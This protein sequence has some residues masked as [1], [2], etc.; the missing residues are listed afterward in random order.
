MHVSAG[1]LLV[2]LD[3]TQVRAN[4]QMLVNQLDQVRMRAARLIAERDD[5][6]E[7]RIPTNFTARMSDAAI[8]QL[9]TSEK[10]QFNARGSARRGQVDVLQSNI[11]QFREQI[12]G[13]EAQIASKTSQLS[14]I[15]GELTGVQELYGKGLVPLARLTTLPPEVARPDG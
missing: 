9:V 4:G 1:G 11:G 15:A 8:A 2:R 6:P 5:A 13:L 7:I 10:S 3:E 14:I 12:A